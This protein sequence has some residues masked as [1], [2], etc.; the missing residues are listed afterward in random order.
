MKNKKRYDNN[1]LFGMGDL[2]TKNYE[3]NFQKL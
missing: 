1:P 2:C 3:R